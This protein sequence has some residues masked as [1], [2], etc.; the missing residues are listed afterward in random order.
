MIEWI[1]YNW[2]ELLQFLTTYGLGVVAGYYY[3]VF[4]D[5]KELKGKK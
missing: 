5:K 4:K 2:I 3:K 1:G